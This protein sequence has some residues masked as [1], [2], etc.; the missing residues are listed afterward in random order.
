ML[1]LGDLLLFHTAK[2]A[3]AILP[4]TTTDF[5]GMFARPLPVVRNSHEPVREMRGKS[6]VAWSGDGAKR[7]TRCPAARGKERQRKHG[8]SHART[9][10][11]IR[12]D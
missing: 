2:V 3:T 10:R 6:Q 8:R 7:G 12:R 9:K 1:G 11:Q 4:D 5:A